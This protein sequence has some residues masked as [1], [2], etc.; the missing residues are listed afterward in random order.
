MS[1]EQ[2]SIL[3]LKPRSH[4]NIER[5]LKDWFWRQNIDLPVVHMFHF[6]SRVL[7]RV[8]TLCM[9]TDNI[10]KFRI[11]LR[12]WDEELLSMIGE[13]NARQNTNNHKLNCGS[14]AGKRWKS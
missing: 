4:V 1:G 7:S 10:G 3:S 14:I 13:T 11:L 6:P 12:P 8:L 9:I 2:F 5:G